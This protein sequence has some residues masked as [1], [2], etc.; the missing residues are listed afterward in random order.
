MH[1]SRKPLPRLGKSKASYNPPCEEQPA[2]E[3]PL[4]IVSLENLFEVPEPKAVSTQLQMKDGQGYSVLENVQELKLTPER[5]Q[6]KHEDGAKKIVVNQRKYKKVPEASESKERYIA[7]SGERLEEY[8][9]LQM[10]NTSDITFGDILERIENDGYKIGQ[11]KVAYDHILKAMR[12]LMS[13]AQSQEIAPKDEHE[14]PKPVITKTEKL[15]LPEKWDDEK[16]RSYVKSEYE[17][18]SKTNL[19]TILTELQRKG[20]PVSKVKKRMIFNYFMELRGE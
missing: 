10:K 5:V 12:R 4:E 2:E 9:K 7:L 11:K 16:A 18:N 1:R 3:K 19:T 6:R 13:S 17:R 8:V 20:Y 15:P 14:S